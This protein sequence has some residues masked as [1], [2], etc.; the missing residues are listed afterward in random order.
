M[1]PQGGWNIKNFSWWWNCP[2]NE[3]LSW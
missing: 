1:G 3:D 2:G